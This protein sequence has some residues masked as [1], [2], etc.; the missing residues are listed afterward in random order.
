[1]APPKRKLL[2]SNMY[3]SLARWAFRRGKVVIAAWIIIL[4]GVNAIAGA[5]G[6]AFSAEFSTPESESTRGFAVLNEHFPG[7]SSAFSGNIV[8]KA[9]QG[10]T[11]PEV[12]EQMSAMFLEVDG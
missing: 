12:V 5:I 7:S 1:M 2:T 3:A 11:D 9:E 8:F 10:V 6:T 4:F